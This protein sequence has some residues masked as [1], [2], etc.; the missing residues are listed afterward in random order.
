MIPQ[1]QKKSTTLK[2]CQKEKGPTSIEYVKLST[3]GILTVNDTA[4]YFRQ[5]IILELISCILVN[6]Q[7][8]QEQWGHFFNSCCQPQRFLVKKSDMETTR[9]IYG[10]KKIEGGLCG[11]KFDQ[12]TTIFVEFH[13]ILNLSIKQVLVLI[14]E[15]G[16]YK[17]CIGLFLYCFFF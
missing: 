6:Q 1:Q 8:Q 9:A 12:K 4:N 11:F 13:L 2:H 16:D 7:K 14:K 5:T 10:E 17:F 3:T 15:N